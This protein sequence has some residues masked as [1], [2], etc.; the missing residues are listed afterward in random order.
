MAEQLNL[1]L[2]L[3]TAMGRDDF[4]VA[5]SNALALAMIDQPEAWALGKL[6]LSGPAGSGKTHLAHVWASDCGAT[7]MA[8]RDLEETDAPALAIAPVVVEDV[9]EIAQ[10]RSR[11]T[12]L[13]HLHNLMQDTR[14][15]LML[16]GRA[17]PNLWGLSLPDMQSRVD[18]ASAASLDAPDDSLLAAVLAKQFYDRQLTPRPDVIPYLLNRME[19]SFEAARLT[20]AA[21]DQASLR[22]KHAITQRFA[23]RVLD[24]M[25]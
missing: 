11:L 25:Q 6:A 12:A 3:R 2:P 21:L 22:E 13:F 7:L 15:P 23:G 10:D 24:K 9:P 16:T 18:A 4:M 5:P 1:T 19:R 17:A 14:Q 8:A 20:V